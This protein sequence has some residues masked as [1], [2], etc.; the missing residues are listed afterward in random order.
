MKKSNFILPIVFLFFT[1]FSSCQVTPR[2]EY[3]FD[4]ILNYKMRVS[5]AD[6]SQFKNYERVK[7]YRLNSKDD[8]LGGSLLYADSKDGEEE[9]T[10]LDIDKEISLRLITNSKESGSV[11]MM[12]LKGLNPGYIE[13]PFKKT[14]K[15]ETIESY[16]C[17][18]W[19]CE[20]PDP[21][22]TCHVWTAKLPIGVP[23]HAY[24]ATVG[25]SYRL[26]KEGLGL[27]VRVTQ[28]TNDAYTEYYLQSHRKD[29]YVLK[30][31]DHEL[32]EFPR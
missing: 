8:K 17:E 13:N 4:Y 21:I 20:Q 30:M 24:L 27:P 6:T 15:K 14:G 2:D 18:E 3:N 19:V 22:G 32:T 1:T 7:G 10:I 16:E 9:L 28:K 12:V 23:T 25:I 5:F 31:S 11:T 29:S 26:V